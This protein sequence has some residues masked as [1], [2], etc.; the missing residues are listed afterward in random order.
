MD[1][2]RKLLI[3]N[4]LSFGV[5]GAI[6]AAWAPMVPFV[7]MGMNLDDAQFGRLLLSMGIG[8]LCALP[9][10][11]LLISKFGPRLVAITGCIVLG[12]SLIGISFA[13]HEWL[14]CLIL[15]IFGASLIAI[16]VASNVNAVVVESIFKRPLMSG[17]HGGYSLGTIVGSMIMSL[18]LTIGLGIHLS[19][20]LIFLI[21]TGVT[22]IGCR[23]LFSDIKSFNA[24]HVKAAQTTTNTKHHRV[25]PVILVLGCLC[26]IMYGSEGALLSW[27]TV[28]A[29]QNRGITP[30]VAGY[31]YNFF[32]VTMTVARYSGNKLVTA[33]GR[34]RTV[35][36]GAIMV[37]TGFFITA[38]VEHYV[39]MMIGFTIIGLGA[40]NIVPQLVSFAGS[41]PGI[42][43]QSAISLINSLGYSGILLG[44]V[45]IG[46]VSKLSSL[47]R[48][49]E[50]L[51]IA[52][53]VVAL[54]SFKIL[55]Q[56]K[57][58]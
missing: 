3:S 43:V 52:V 57:R 22:L 2:N 16:D 26:F 21:M 50:L 40:G 10:V 46:Y 7:K 24:E 15:A 14:L 38:S 49:F 44:P 29:T 11:G 8:S 17:F 55:K 58:S 37:A 56:A 32:A 36:L 23:A 19:S 30:E 4:Q 33:F 39:G 13:N 20:F 6:E 28:F 53:F 41:V 34:R 45:I 25:P 5:L 47:E 18:L 48:S 42:K 9:T 51:G 27:T 31:F 54:V 1:Q 35:V 12:L